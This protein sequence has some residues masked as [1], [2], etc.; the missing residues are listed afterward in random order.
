MTSFYDLLTP[1]IF[2]NYHFQVEKL[3]EK[4]KKTLKILSDTILLPHTESGSLLYTHTP[5]HSKETLSYKYNT[6]PLKKKALKWRSANNMVLCAFS[7][8]VFM[9]Y[10]HAPKALNLNK[11]IH[12]CQRGQL[13]AEHVSCFQETR[14]SIHSPVLSLCQVT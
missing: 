9:S 11:C 14:E 5:E 8:T 3:E 12:K 6:R 4:K 2:S 10:I 1:S 7:V 13:S